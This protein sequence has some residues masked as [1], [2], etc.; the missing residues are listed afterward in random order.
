MRFYLGQVLCWA[1]FSLALAGCA[2]VTKVVQI[3]P[4]TYSVGAHTGAATGSG[5]G[6]NADAL[7]AAS[8]YCGAMNRK[9]LVVN[10][11]QETGQIDAL[12]NATVEFKC[13]PN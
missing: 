5:A 9:L 11:N 7:D 13:T 1:V 4:D 3:G 12:G 6:A 2:S 8:K 10:D